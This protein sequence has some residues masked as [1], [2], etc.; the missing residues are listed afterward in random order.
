MLLPRFMP[1]SL[2]RKSIRLILERDGDSGFMR[3]L[4][5][6]TDKYSLKDGKKFDS[7]EDEVD[8]LIK[9]IPEIKHLRV[10]LVSFFKEVRI[11]YGLVK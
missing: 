9:K 2:I 4:N 5:D 7:A 3:Y 8:D 11:K 1:L 10:Q 6:Q